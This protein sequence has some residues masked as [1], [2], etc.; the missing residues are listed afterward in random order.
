MLLFLLNVFLLIIKKMFSQAFRIPSSNRLPELTVAQ[1]N[2]IGNYVNE[3]KLQRHNLSH[4]CIV[5]L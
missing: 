1:Q 2:M 3:R 4:V 5:A